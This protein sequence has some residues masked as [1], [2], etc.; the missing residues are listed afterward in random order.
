MGLD[1]LQGELA[2]VLGYE[3]ATCIRAIN[4][5]MEG[6]DRGAE[7]ETPTPMDSSSQK[8]REE[9]GVSQPF[10]KQNALEWFRLTQEIEANSQGMY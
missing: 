7:S 2:K 9:V 3:S 10:T 8:N 6:I 5:F 1:L 4:D